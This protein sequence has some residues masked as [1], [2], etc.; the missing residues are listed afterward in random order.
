MK[1]FY[2]IISFIAFFNFLKRTF[3]QQIEDII[4]GKEYSG[5]LEIQEN[6]GLNNYNFFKLQINDEIK[7]AKDKDLIIQVRPVQTYRSISDPDL[8]V[9]KVI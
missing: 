9:S 8:Y 2:L 1:Y 4:L 7:K 3:C 6:A 5:T